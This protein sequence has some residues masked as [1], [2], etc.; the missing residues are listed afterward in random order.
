MIGSRYSF[1]WFEALGMFPVAN[2]VVVMVEDGR[3]E[4]GGQYA[5]SP[6]KR[7]PPHG[8]FRLHALLLPCATRLLLAH[9]GQVGAAAVRD[10]GGHAH[11]FTQ[12]GVG[13]DGLADVGGV[14]AHFDGQADFADHVAGRRADDGATDDAVRFG[15]EDQLGEAV[16]GAVGDGA[17]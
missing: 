6:E 4:V 12:G 10:F 17:A 5:C 15:V 3:F 16:V 2:Q 7:N 8:G 11:G 13:V 1:H 14:G 9:R